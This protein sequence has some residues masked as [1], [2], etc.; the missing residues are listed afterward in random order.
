MKRRD[1]GNTIKVLVGKR[2]LTNIGE[3]ELN[4]RKLNSALAG[5]ANHLRRQV[6]GQHL[7]GT[8][9]QTP[10]ERTGAAANFQHVT[11]V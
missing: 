7:L 2:P 8:L 3:L 11:T 10:R 4:I 1:A 9:G 5:K 6:E